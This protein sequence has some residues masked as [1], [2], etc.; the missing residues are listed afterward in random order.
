VD[1]G[2]ASSSKRAEVARRSL[3]AAAIGVVAWIVLQPTAW[4][5]SLS[6]AELEQIEQ[7]VVREVI[8][9]RYFSEQ[10][11][12][13][14]ELIYSR[15]GFNPQIEEVVRATRSEDRVERYRGVM[16]LEYL[17]RSDLPPAAWQAAADVMR[18]PRNSDTIAM[19]AAKML[20]ANRERGGPDITEPF[21][22]A[23]REKPRDAANLA[24][25]L[26]SYAPRQQ[27][28]RYGMDRTLPV[29]VRRGIVSG[30]GMPG[31]SGVQI[32]EGLEP[33]LWEIASSDPDYEIRQ[34]A[35]LALRLYEKPRPWRAILENKQM[36]RTV[37][38][39]TLL[40]LFFTPALIIF[41]GL[42]V[43]RR[44]LL[45]LWIVLSLWL[46]LMYGLTLVAGLGHAKRSDFL[47]AFLVVAITAGVQVVLLV[48]AFRQRRARLREL[49]YDSPTATAIQAPAA[50]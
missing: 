27:I 46:V 12:Q 34:S 40:V 47:E 14:L 21:F 7:N 13:Q 48:L 39:T 2:S 9:E 41:V 44:W 15:S 43:A 17:S 42:F 25:L 49:N 32:A 33:L 31:S 45:V 1:A 3:F 6:P 37:L 5:Q 11:R 19:M 22:A 26:S 20:A 28:V 36:Y 23:M 35:S 29:E 4:A 30:G 24:R 8:K 38:D 16:R 10:H 50:K 18:D